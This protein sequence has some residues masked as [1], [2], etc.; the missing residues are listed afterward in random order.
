MQSGWQDYKCVVESSVSSE[1]CS[2]CNSGVKHWPCTV[3]DQ[4]ACSRRHFRCEWLTM[5]QVETAGEGY[6][7]DRATHSV[8][9]SDSKHW[10]TT[11]FLQPL[12]YLVTPQ[13]P[14]N[15]QL[16]SSF[17]VGAQT[18]VRLLQTTP[19]KQ[20]VS[21]IAANKVYTSTNQTTIVWIET[22]LFSLPGVDASHVY[23]RAALALGCFYR[24]ISTRTFQRALTASLDSCAE[25][26]IECPFSGVTIGI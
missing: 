1:H 18:V 12:P 10:Y 4:W 23:V 9:D 3:L 5:P 8:L 16:T 19:I 7:T 17:V 15:C 11:S 22:E 21:F 25:I 24:H 6:E 20:S 2:P 26:K 13:G 14:E